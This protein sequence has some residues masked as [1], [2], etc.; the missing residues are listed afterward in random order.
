MIAQAYG[1]AQY[2][3]MGLHSQRAVI[4]LTLFSFPIAAV[5]A[6]T[7]SILYYVFRIGHQTS[8]LAGYWAR[9]IVFG[10]WPTLMFQ[11]FRRYLQGCGILWPVTVANFCSAVSVVAGTHMLIHHFH[12]GFRGA[13]IGVV[14]S[15][16]IRFLVL[17]LIIA[18]M[19]RFLKYD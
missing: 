4:I 7:G 11:I 19:H 9:H 18:G 8:N 17:V 14:I 13:A 2:Q 1:G 12:M 16:W 10:L 15:Q 5:W 6:Y 3:L